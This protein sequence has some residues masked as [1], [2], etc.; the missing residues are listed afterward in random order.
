M[1]PQSDR[2]KAC[3]ACTTNRKKC[4]TTVHVDKLPRTE[5]LDLDDIEDPSE[6]LEEKSENTGRRGKCLF[7]SFRIFDADW[8]R[9]RIPIRR[10]ASQE[11]E[12]WISR[13]AVDSAGSDGV[14]AVSSSSTGDVDTGARDGE[15]AEG[16][17]GRA[18][19]GAGEEVGGGGLAK[20]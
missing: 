17:C 5:T 18:H 14:F 16:V 20:G 8:F 7:V 11:A 15:G 1:R 4:V 12:D 10:Q 3:A 13:W 2:S 19:H 6:E 9:A